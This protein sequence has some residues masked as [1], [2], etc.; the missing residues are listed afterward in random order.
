M[1]T[2]CSMPLTT[3]LAMFALA[4]CVIC[5]CAN[6]PEPLQAAR[7][8][9]QN[10]DKE[11]V[12]L[13]KLLVFAGLL[14]ALGCAGFWALTAPFTWASL[15]PSRDVADAGP[16]DIANGHALF[17]AGSCGTCH[18]S[19]GQKDELRLG[20]GGALTSGFGTFYMPNI[21]PDP[22]DGIGSWT[23]AQFVRAVR[24]GVSDHGANEYPALPYTS[25]QRMTA[26]DLRD[27][28]GY[29]KTLPAVAG[30]ARDNDLNFPFTLRRG[31][32]LWRLVFL[33]G[34]PL[35][36]PP[37]KSPAWKRGQYLVEGPGHCA[38]CHSPRNFMGAVIADKRLSGGPDPDG[39][40]YVPN[41][42]SDETGIGYWST[43]EIAD[44]LGTGVTPVN[45]QAGGSMTAIV[46]NMAHLS[47]DDRAA[48]AGYIKSL[49]AIDA[50]NAG[51]PE[52]NRTPVIRM[53]PVA[54]LG[55]RSPASALAAPA[56][57]LAA[58]TTVYSVATKPLF[59]DQKGA[60]PKS[61]GDGRLLPAAKVSVV[62]RDGD[63]L[64]VRVD[65]WQ[66]DGSP[67]AFYALQGQRILVAALGP[68]MMPKVTRGTGVQ[69]AATKLTWFPG[70]FTAWIS[71]D[72][73]N[74][75]VAKI[76]AYSG[77][78]YSASC[79]SC[80]AL[81]PANEYLTNQWLGSLA[82]MKRFTALD[83]GQYRLLLAYL[84]FHSKDV[85]ATTLG[86]NST[87]VSTAVGQAADKADDKP[88]GNPSTSPAASSNGKL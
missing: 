64:Q 57:A 55:V 43:R 39:N 75:E 87:G 27:L 46:A 60:S 78:L 20:G 40:G 49:P 21:S 86:L 53:L 82:T 67:A 29:I 15:H 79:G 16:S 52:P 18:V 47:A 23:T 36:V 31:V 4:N 25:Y 70:S 76:W 77:Q 1:V 72:D 8:P 33:D 88:P 14:F 74:P 85:G 17:Y 13:K 56:D 26:N 10:R 66:Q 41:I 51:A 30:K 28:F 54:S 45:T 12:P 62:A 61:T 19:P 2:L 59:L 38:E 22:T 81:H 80:H 42:T 34:E 24:D 11:S 5:L 48:M 71:K 58:A 3:P 73:L 37:D 83:D 84:Q 63:W 6:V 44:Y 9:G 65:G 69:D 35:V 68:A 7:S 50:P 32:G